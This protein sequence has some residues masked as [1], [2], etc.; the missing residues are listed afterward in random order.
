MRSQQYKIK[1]DR[2]RIK[3]GVN[4]NNNNKTGLIF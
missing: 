2:K 3:E 1:K 4:S